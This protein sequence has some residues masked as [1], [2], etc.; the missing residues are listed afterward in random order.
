MK[1][2]FIT[3]LFAI[4]MFTCGCGKEEVEDVVS[5]EIPKPETITDSSVTI[6]YDEVTVR[7]DVAGTE[8]FGVINS[9]GFTIYSSPDLFDSA[10]VTIRYMPNNSRI[11]PLLKDGTMIK[12]VGDG[13]V[14]IGK[15]DGI[16]DKELSVILDN[17]KEDSYI[18]CST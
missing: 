17:I 16:S 4:T 8:A 10:T 3:V 7:Y 14:A 11:K 2:V 6:S 13:Y 18:P 15:S 9:D 1:K 12:E 5:T